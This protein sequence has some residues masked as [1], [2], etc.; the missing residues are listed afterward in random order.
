LAY[1]AY[2]SHDA[3]LAGGVWLASAGVNPA[4]ASQAIDSILAEFDRLGN[5][6]VPEAELA[7]S[8]SY[9]TGVLP[10]TL[11]TNEGVAAT[12]LNMEWYG[13]GLDYLQRYN[14]LIY[15]VTPADVQRVARQYLRADTY[16]LVT[17]GP[18][19]TR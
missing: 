2:S 16:T 18:G 6:S 7:D 9:M 11:E 14:G 13:L 15:G 17:A 3:D 5:E 19:M 12:L 8:Q 1:Y 4:H 10:L